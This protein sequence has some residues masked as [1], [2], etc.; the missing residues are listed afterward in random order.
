MLSW[1]TLALL[2][3]LPML[4]LDRLPVPQW[5]APCWLLVA[6]WVTYRAY[7][8]DKS[9]AQSGQ[10]RIPET[11]LHFCE[12]IGGWPGA[13]IAQRRLRHKIAKGPYQFVFWIILILHQI[14]AAD[15]LTG[16]RGLRRI[17]GWLQET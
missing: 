5:A 3:V 14:A 10:W 17:I 13:W 4:A 2:L 7:A 11:R 9:R 8:S 12:L 16:W 1:I 6:S 15:S